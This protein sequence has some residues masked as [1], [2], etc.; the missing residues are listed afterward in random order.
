M[1][2]AKDPTHGYSA[3]VPAG[4]VVGDEGERGAAAGALGAGES[5]PTLRA[6][7]C[8][9]R[10]TFEALMQ[11]LPH[12]IPL[13]QFCASAGRAAPKEKALAKT[14]PQAAKGC[15]AIAGTA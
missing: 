9:T 4:G 8:P 14:S 11:L 2:S 3:G 13:R 12:G 15:L 6:V 10:Q 1:P 5:S 7:P